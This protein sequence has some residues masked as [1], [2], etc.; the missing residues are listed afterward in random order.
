MSNQEDNAPNAQ[1]EERDAATRTTENVNVE[2]TDEDLD[3][4]SGGIGN[5]F[6]VHPG[7]P[8]PPGP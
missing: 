5:M 1:T 6:P 7:T 3:K 8:H 2:L 4:V